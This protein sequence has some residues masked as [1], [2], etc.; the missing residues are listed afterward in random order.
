VQ[1]VRGRQ[2]LSGGRLQQQLKMGS[3][4][5]RLQQQLRAGQQAATEQL[6]GHFL[7]EKRK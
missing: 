5:G 4:G 6:A 1:G 2:E 7:Y 3:D